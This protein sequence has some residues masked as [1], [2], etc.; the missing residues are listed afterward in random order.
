MEKY[1]NNGIIEFLKDNHLVIISCLSVI[2]VLFL[3][4]IVLLCKKKNKEIKELKNQELIN[5][6]NKNEDSCQKQQYGARSQVFLQSNRCQQFTNNITYRG[7]QLGVN[8]V[9]T[10]NSANA[11]QN[12]KEKT[13]SSVPAVPSQSASSCTYNYL[14]EANG[15][16][17][18][19]L[20]S[21]PDKCFFRTWEE[22]GVRKYE[23]CGNVGKAL[24]NINAIFDDVCEI[25]GKG[26]HATYI[27]NVSA[28]TLDSELRITSKAKI[29]LK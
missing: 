1:L 21:K 6:C 13:S 12:K 5:S 28:G 22:G 20:L 8:G 29:R 23:F 2:I 15:G 18:L 26:S 9:T 7:L 11:S 24:A 17:F 25:D 3:F 14:Q 27:E 10:S 4:A 19:K 16:R